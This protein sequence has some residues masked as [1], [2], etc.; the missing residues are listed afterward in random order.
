M[1]L[2][3]IGIWNTNQTTS[4]L[5]WQRA[6]KALNKVNRPLQFKVVNEVC[7]QFPDIG[8]KPHHLSRGKGARQRA[9]QVRMIRRVA[10]NLPP[11]CPPP[12]IT[13][14]KPPPHSTDPRAAP[15]NY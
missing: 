12:H 14:P 10:G 8:F 7:S 15:L 5:Q 1:N 13:T 6:S 9:P 11:L 4:N 2:I 3:V